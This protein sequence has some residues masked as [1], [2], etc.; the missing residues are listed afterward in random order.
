VEQQHRRPRTT[1]CY[2]DL[3][4][5]LSGMGWCW[6]GLCRELIGFPSDETRQGFRHVAAEARGLTGFVCHG[7]R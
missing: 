7:I 4:A 3:T 5:S 6:S 1:A 2:R